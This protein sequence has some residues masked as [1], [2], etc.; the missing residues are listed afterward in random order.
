MS[1]LSEDRWNK[2]QPRLEALISDAGAGSAQTTSDILD[3]TRCRQWR[4]CKIQ[5]LT[6][7]PHCGAAASGGPDFAYD[8]C[9]RRVSPEQR[10]SLDLGRWELAFTGVEPVRAGTLERPEEYRWRSPRASSSDGKQG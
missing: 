8:L 9:V 4:F 6:A 3:R 7:I 5:W 2:Y 1:G 10:A